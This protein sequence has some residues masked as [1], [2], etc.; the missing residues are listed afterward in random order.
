MFPLFRLPFHAHL[1]NQIA[2][3]SDRR[4]TIPMNRAYYNPSHEGLA[5]TENGVL[6]RVRVVLGV[7]LDVLFGVTPPSAVA[8]PLGFAHSIPSS[9]DNLSPADALFTG[10]P[11]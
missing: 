10:K 7:L 9:L 1:I 3:N 6:Y 11:P 8:P 2:D 5:V 4:M